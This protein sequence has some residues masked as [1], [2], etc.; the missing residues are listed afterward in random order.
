MSNGICGRC[1]SRVGYDEKVSVS[2]GWHL[3]SESV[4]VDGSPRHYTRKKTR[5]GLLCRKCAEEISRSMGVE[6]PEEVAGDA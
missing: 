6:V 4:D 1:G 3:A 2:F 5:R